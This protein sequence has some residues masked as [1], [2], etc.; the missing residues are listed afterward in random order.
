[1]YSGKLLHWPVERRTRTFRVHVV[2]PAAYAPTGHGEIFKAVLSNLISPPRQRL[3]GLGEARAATLPDSFDL[4]TF[5]EAFISTQVLI[6]ALQAIVDA[7]PVGCVHVGLRPDDNPNSHLFSQQQ[8]IEL[9]SGIRAVSPSAAGD[10][11]AVATWFLTQHAGHMFNFGCLFTVDAE[12]RVRVCLHP[13]II[14]SRFEVNPLPEQHME[15]AD[16]LSLVTLDPNDKRFLSITLQPLICSD[17]LNQQRDRAGNPPILA[18]STDG[19]EC[20]GDLP[21]DHIDIVSVATHT[22]QPEA[23]GEAPTYRAW[24]RQFQDA[25]VRA[26]G[27]GGGSRHYF[28]SFVLSNFL[29]LKGGKG[30]GLSGV[31]MPIK[32]K[33]GKFHDA[34]VA[35]LYGKPIDGHQANNEWSPPTI[36]VPPSWSSLGFLATLDPFCGPETAVVKVFGFTIQR[37]PRDHSPWTTAETL[38]RCE[39]RV[40]VRNNEGGLSFG[41]WSAAYV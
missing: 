18:I 34:I 4:I 10:L 1:M 36:E 7:G 5:P 32:A 3:D 20:F 11:E 40:G 16:F 33:P 14:R 29:K 24:H 30:G 39:V 19:A 9:I 21:P 28:A 17:V 6:E 38:T 8:A 12:Q 27:D 26:A 37:F 25:F 22:P 41:D 2:E 23:N 13:K 35:S 31:F 15:E